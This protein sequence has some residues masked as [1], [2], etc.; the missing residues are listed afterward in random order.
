MMCSSSVCTEFYMY[1]ITIIEIQVYNTNRKTDTTKSKIKYTLQLVSPIKQQ[2]VTLL[3]ITLVLNY[4]I[5]FFYRHC[6]GNNLQQQKTYTWR[7][8]KKCVHF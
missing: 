6:T 3:K 7:V 4:L 2:F 1:S 5:Y 8:K